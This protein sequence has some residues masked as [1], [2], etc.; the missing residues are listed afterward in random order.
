MLHPREFAVYAALLSRADARTRECYPSYGTLASDSG[1]ARRQV[2]FAL[3]ELIDEGLVSKRLGRSVNRYIVERFA[4][5]RPEG[6]RSRFERGDRLAVRATVRETHSAPSDDVDTVRETRSEGP[7]TVRETPSAE[8]AIST[9]QSARDA[10][11]PYPVEPDPEEPSRVH[12]D[13]THAETDDDVDVSAFEAAAAT[14]AATTTRITDRQFALL[15]D[16]CILAGFGTPS[17]RTVAWMRS[18]TV[19][20]FEGVKRNWMR[21]RDSRGRGPGY[22][23]PG[24]GDAE[25]EHLSARGKQWADVGC[26]PGEMR[27]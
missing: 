13:A 17:D 4:D 1:V 7:D 2:G 10:L 11:E 9:P 27:R 25:Y 14:S 6:F 20:Q 3:A 23:G 18:L 16:W 19:E 12:R 5:V 15:N 8:C 26:M 24:A 21:E 22:D